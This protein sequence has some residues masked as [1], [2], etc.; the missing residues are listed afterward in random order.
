MSKPTIKYPIP[1]VI[2]N[3]KRACKKNRVGGY[4]EPKTKKISGSKI[5]KIR[6]EKALI[7]LKKAPIINR[8][9]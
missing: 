7:Q 4:S 3:P 5:D 9:L 6:N 1:K 8:Y 2:I